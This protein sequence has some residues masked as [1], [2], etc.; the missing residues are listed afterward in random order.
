MRLPAFLGALF[1]TAA[2]LRPV[3]A[4]S[5][6]PAASAS[7]IAHKAMYALTLDHANN[8]DIVGAHGTMSYEVT[9]A[10]DAWIVHQQL[11]LIVTNADG[12]TID[13]DSDYATWEAKDGLKFRFHMRQTT[14]TAVTSATDG[15]ATLTRV[16]GPGEAHYT[17]PEKKTVSLPAGTVFPMAQTAALIAA[18][19]DGK[20]FL[21]L[22]LFD[23]T[24]ENGAEDSFTILLDR[25]K[26]TPT[27]WPALS[28]LPSTRA[29]ISFFDHD[30]RAM[31]PSFQVNVRY[32]K[33]GVADGMRMDFGDFVMKGH[34]VR[35]MPGRPHC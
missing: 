17:L 24:D 11:R 32:W 30:P 16:G 15:E 13:M 7:L 12:Q 28:A 29:N 2:T 19:A 10:C 31:T 3:A 5:A 22:P 6:P 20:R 35:F 34:M 27:H 33:D 9:D 26:P 25:R 23:G 4:L 8:D 14:D 18:A 1:L 21:A